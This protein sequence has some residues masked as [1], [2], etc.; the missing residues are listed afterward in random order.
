MTGKINS[1]IQSLY[2][3]LAF[4]NAYFKYVCKAQSLCHS[5]RNI[6]D[7]FSCHKRVSDLTIA[8]HCHGM[9]WFGRF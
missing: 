2:T 3:L 1:V 9:L 4:I 6:L 5:E 7:I 8:D